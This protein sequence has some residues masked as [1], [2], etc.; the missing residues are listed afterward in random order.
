MD[1]DD[2]CIVICEEWDLSVP[3]TS[4]SVGAFQDVC[5][6]H[7]DLHNR[8]CLSRFRLSVEDDPICVLQ[9]KLWAVLDWSQGHLPPAVGPPK[10]ARC[11]V[12]KSDIELQTVFV[13]RRRA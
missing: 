5:F 13:L 11:W 3:H 7:D 10:E 12:V 6:D 4:S 1:G 9:D 8:L 2:L